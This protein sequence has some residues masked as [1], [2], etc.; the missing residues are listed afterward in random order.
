MPQES[1]TI[2]GS[3]YLPAAT[4]LSATLFLA[5]LLLGA[6]ATTSPNQR[7]PAAGVYGVS[8]DRLVMI[9]SGSAPSTAAAEM[10]DVGALTY[11]PGAGTFYAV[12]DATSSPRLIAIDP[13]TG[14]ARAVGAIEAAN[15]DLTLVEGLA[16]N[17][18][19]STLYAAGG[20]STFAS[21]VLLIVDPATGAA[22][23]VAR[24]RGTV[25]DEV[26]AMT[27]A[28]DALL[29]VDGAGGS[30]ALYRID[31]DTGQASRLGEPF[32]DTVVDLTFDPAGRR[33]FGAR[34]TDDPLLIISLDGES[35]GELAAG[36]GLSALA[37]IPPA[38]N[39]SLFGDGFE[40]GDAGSW[41]GRPEQK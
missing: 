28:G 24:V 11:D 20:E 6:C 35:L 4:R 34:G 19:D 14:E 32:A 2:R 30:S 21:S 9:G 31:P 15:L 1:A 8:G 39:V 41:S 12:A 25:Q 37:I 33:L 36:A 23:Q 27:F 17:P 26:D 13:T 18:G 7:S 22:R 40:S 10:T 3:M 16:F 29:A 38:G 5:T